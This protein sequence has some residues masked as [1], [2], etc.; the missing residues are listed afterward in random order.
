ME[1]NSDGASLRSRSYSGGPRRS[2]SQANSSNTSMSRS[3][4][5]IPTNAKQH[6]VAASSNI[7]GD[8]T[9]SE[10]T[11]VPD[12]APSVDPFATLRSIPPEVKKYFGGKV[13]PIDGIWLTPHPLS[14]LPPSYHKTLSGIKGSKDLSQNK[15]NEWELDLLREYDDTR[16]EKYEEF[17][18]RCR[19]D[20]EKQLN[21]FVAKQESGKKDPKEAGRKKGKEEKRG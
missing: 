16:M 3:Q 12:D 18:L 10:R 4:R 17:L 20:P 14:L 5:V 15:R 9:S 1:D 7:G 8:E 21:K 6:V 19:R 2:G 11:T 13:G